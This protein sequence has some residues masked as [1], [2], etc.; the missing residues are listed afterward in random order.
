MGPLTPWA[1]EGSAS[2]IDR[3]PDY[4]VNE[5]ESPEQNPCA[6]TDGSCV[7]KAWFAGSLIFFF[8]F[9]SLLSKKYI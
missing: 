4:P 2:L 8:F 9:K 5:G 7:A 6:F 3:P 1:R